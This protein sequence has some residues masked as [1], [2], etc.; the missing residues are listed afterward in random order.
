MGFCPPLA[1]FSQK[2]RFAMMSWLPLLPRLTGAVMHE[3]WI[4]DKMRHIEVSGIRMVF[5]LAA[6]LKDPVNLSIGQPHF[7]VPEPIKQAAKAAIDANRNGYTVTQGV[8]ELLSKIQADLR[9]RYPGHHEREV[10]LTSGTS[11][12]LVLALCSTLNP[13]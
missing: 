7:P 10:F 5:D 6:K 4:A 8:P 9:A 1:K 11:G 3:H 2:S 13:G 12:G